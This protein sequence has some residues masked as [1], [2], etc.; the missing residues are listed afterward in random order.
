M[1]C[2]SSLLGLINV[3]CSEWTVGKNKR[4]KKWNYPLERLMKRKIAG[5]WE[6]WKRTQPSK[7]NW[8]KKITYEYLLKTRKLLDPSRNLIKEIN[9]WA[10]ALATDSE[11]FLESTKES[12]KYGPKAKNVYNYALDVS[13]ERWHWEIVCVKWRMKEELLYIDDCVDAS[14]QGIKDSIQKSKE[15]LI[16]ESDIGNISTNS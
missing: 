7:R 11:P 5:L 13:S 12:L 14:T 9:T 8:R 15:R 6:Y 2:L 3:S 4:Q 10:V 16:I 1:V